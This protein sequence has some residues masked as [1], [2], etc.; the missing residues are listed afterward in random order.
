MSIHDTYKAAVRRH[1]KYKCCGRFG[2]DNK[3]VHVWTSL[4]TASKR[5]AS[6]ISGQFAGATIS[7]STARRV[8]KNKSMDACVERV[9][10][11][12]SKAWGHVEVSCSLIKEA[13]TT[14][15]LLRTYF[16]C[17]VEALHWVQY[18]SIKSTLRESASGI[19]HAW[20]E[21]MDWRVWR[22]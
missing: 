21:R 15:S 5:I 1:E 11:I 22:Q 19:K 10:M 2:V 20:L 6:L 18:H 9:E 8:L 7:S 4:G 13:T 3:V 16:G 14:H 12:W 17:M